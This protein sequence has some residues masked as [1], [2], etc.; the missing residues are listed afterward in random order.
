LI[1]FGVSEDGAG[2]GAATFGGTDT[3][4]G[5][6]EDGGIGGV[7]AVAAAADPRALGG[8]ALW[9]GEIVPVFRGS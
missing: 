6:T 1:F 2:T 9:L 3:A 4:G 5:E 7:V 8:E